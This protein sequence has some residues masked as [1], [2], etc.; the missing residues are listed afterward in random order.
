MLDSDIVYGLTKMLK[1]LAMHLN[2]SVHITSKVYCVHC[3]ATIV[4]YMYSQST[5]S[6]TRSAMVGPNPTK[7]EAAVHDSQ[8]LNHN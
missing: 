5:N 7:N 4:T 6:S 3:P 2:G 1:Y 8:M